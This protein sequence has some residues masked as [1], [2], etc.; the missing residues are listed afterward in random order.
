MI[1]TETTSSGAQATNGIPAHLSD[2][3]LRRNNPTLAEQRKLTVASCV[4]WSLFALLLGIPLV[5]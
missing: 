4:V 3:A 1:P 2:E 5:A